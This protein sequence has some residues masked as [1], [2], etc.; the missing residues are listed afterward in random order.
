MN[1]IC[2]LNKS[3][4]KIL[5]RRMN[6]QYAALSAMTTRAVAVTKKFITEKTD[7]HDRTRRFVYSNAHC[8]GEYAEG[9]RDAD[10][11]GE[12][13]CCPGLSAVKR[14]ANRGAEITKAR[15]LSK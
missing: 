3:S 2:W 1:S 5:T 13:H 12:A 8:A 9:P 6:A 10:A 15:R 11:R 7:E 4:K 14:S